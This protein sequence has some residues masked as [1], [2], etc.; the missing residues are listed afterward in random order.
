VLV[1]E[2][3]TLQ[4]DA[5]RKDVDALLDY[6]RRAPGVRMALPT[7]EHFVPVIATLGAAAGDASA[8]QFPIEGFMGG[9]FTRR[10]VQYG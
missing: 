4:I 7:H 10:S 2:E 6:R 8:A 1:G 5:E 3:V 9:S